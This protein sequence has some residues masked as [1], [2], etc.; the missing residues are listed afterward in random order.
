MLSVVLIPLLPLLAV[1]INGIF[2]R[3]YLKESSHYFAVGSVAISFVLSVSLLVRML[4]GAAD[5][6]STSDF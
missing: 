6:T 1:L 4:S 2:G 3:K 5:S